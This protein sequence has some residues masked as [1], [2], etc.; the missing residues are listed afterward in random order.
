MNSAFRG[1]FTYLEKPDPPNHFV[2]R[3]TKSWEIKQAVA[4]NIKGPVM[5]RMPRLVLPIIAITSHKE[6]PGATGV[7]DWP[8]DS[9]EKAGAKAGGYVR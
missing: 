2:A 6:V 4:C 7:D 5:A 1:Q 8:D 3:P 9:K